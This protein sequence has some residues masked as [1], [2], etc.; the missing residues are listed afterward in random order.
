MCEWL[1][2]QYHKDDENEEAREKGGMSIW[3][4]YRLNCLYHGAKKKKKKKV[5]AI[6][7]QYIKRTCYRISDD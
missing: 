4:R 3:S 6:I 2:K 7:N 1:T 5:W